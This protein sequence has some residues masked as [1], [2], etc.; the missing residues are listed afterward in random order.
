LLDFRVGSSGV[1]V[2]QGL[3]TIKFRTQ[4][5]FDLLG[6]AQ[7]STTILEKRTAVKRGKLG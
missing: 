1:L 6:L 5:P 4:K 7:T 2:G 3:E